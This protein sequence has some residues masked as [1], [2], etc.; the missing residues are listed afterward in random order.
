MQLY[1]FKSLDNIEFVL[2]IVLKERLY[3]CAYDKLNDPFEGLFF[4]SGGFSSA[5]SVDFQIK[6]IEKIIEPLKICSLSSSLDDVRLWSFYADGH[7]GIAIKIDLAEAEDCVNKVDY[8][9]KLP[10]SDLTSPDPFKILSRKTKHWNYECEYRIIHKKD[11]YPIKGRIKAIYIGERI[12][13]IHLDLLKKIIPNKIPMYTT[14]TD[15]NE[16]IIKP[17]ELLKRNCSIQN[18][19]QNLPNETNKNQ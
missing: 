5:F 12:S 9:D 11:Y 10:T 18:E 19:E 14:K 8:C 2:D 3:C 17:D 1:K 16:I 6:K 7:K 15:P 4:I 13:K